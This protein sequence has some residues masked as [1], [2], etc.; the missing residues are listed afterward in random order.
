MSTADRK[1]SLGQSIR[2]ERES[3]NISLRRFA[4]MVGLGHSY[5]IDVENGRRN[6]GYDNLCKIADGLGVT[7]GQLTDK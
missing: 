3:Q 4:A 2:A 6:I 5:L 7:V 1:K